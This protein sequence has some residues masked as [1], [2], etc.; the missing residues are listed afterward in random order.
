MSSQAGVRGA[1][2][3]VGSGEE[4][5]PGSVGTPGGEQAGRSQSHHKGENSQGSLGRRRRKSIDTR[6]ALSNDLWLAL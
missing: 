4:A 2:R 1:K 6:Y 5:K 3:K